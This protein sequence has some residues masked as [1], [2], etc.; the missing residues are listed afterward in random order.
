MA[1]R[2]TARTFGTGSQGYTVAHRTIEG[3]DILV[4]KDDISCEAYGLIDSVN[5]WLGRVKNYNQSSVLCCELQNAMINIGAM[6]FSTLYATYA[7]NTSKTIKRL[8]K[9]LTEIDPLLEATEFILY[10]VDHVHADWLILN[11]EI[12]KAESKFVGW[13]YSQ[14][15]SLEDMQKYGQQIDLLNT[16]SKWAFSEARYYALLTEQQ[17]QTWVSEHETTN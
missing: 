12:R 10:G 15:L 3:K 8:E 4:R 11:T 14:R 1:S 7:D 2:I 6:I 13:V 9:R 16:M 5:A 17:Q